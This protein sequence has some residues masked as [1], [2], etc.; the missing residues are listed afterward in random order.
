M[1]TTIFK[2]K[3]ITEGIKHRLNEAEDQITDLEDKVGKKNPNQSSKK[4]Q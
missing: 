2:M 1:K 4:K 3:N